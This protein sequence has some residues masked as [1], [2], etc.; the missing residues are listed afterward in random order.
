MA[1]K[2]DDK[3]SEKTKSALIDD[4]NL[5]E[6]AKE[7]NEELDSKEMLTAILAKQNDMS[8]DIKSLITTVA[9]VQCDVETLKPLVDTVDDLT[10]KY[11]EMEQRLTA[12]ETNTN[13]N[14]ILDEVK[15]LLSKK[16]NDAK[17]AGRKKEL[18]ALIDEENKNVVISNLT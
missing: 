3:D 12:V 5:K 2:G 10:E 4:D 6:D 17:F 9:C 11:K 16:E 13:K 18:L 15:A 8:G 7:V 14:E 1:T